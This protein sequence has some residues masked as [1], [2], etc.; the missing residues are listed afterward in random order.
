M[1]SATAAPLTVGRPPACPGNRSRFMTLGLDERNAQW[2]RVRGRLRAEF[3]DGVFRSWLKPMTLTG[4][5][6]GVIRIAVPTRF[7]RDRINALYGDRL[8]SL[9]AA[10]DSGV[11]DVELVV[12]P[13]TLGR[14]ASAA[15][16]AGASGPNGGSNGHGVAGS[17]SSGAGAEMADWVQTISAPLDPRFTFDNFV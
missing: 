8:R 4:V 13:T 3:G 10:E 7:M 2:A 15:E 17:A 9:W 6:D 16:S 11:V 12:T 14:P 1:R 5:S